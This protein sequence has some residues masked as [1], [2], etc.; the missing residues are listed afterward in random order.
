M[1]EKGRTQAERIPERITF[2]KIH[3]PIEIPHLLDLQKNSFDWLI[4]NERWK[5][6]IKKSQW[7]DAIGKRSGFDEVF[8]EFSPISDEQ[9]RMELTFSEPALEEA[10]YSMQECKE[11]GLT[12]AAPLYVRAEFHDIKKDIRKKQTVF[13][14]DFPLMTET[15][16]FVFN[17]TE[18]VVLTQIA[19]S[20]GVYFEKSTQKGNDRELFS[21]RIVPTRGSWLEFEIDRKDVV[22][23]RVDRKRRQGVI[24]FLKAIGLTN[25]DI[26][27]HFGQYPI[28]MRAFEKNADLTRE[29][30]LESVY[31]NAR[32]GEP[33]NPE[34]GQMLLDNMFFDE[35]RY[36]LSKIGRYKLNKKLGVDEPVENTVLT[37][38]DIISVAQYLCAMHSGKEEYTA[39][40]TKKAKT[41]RIATDDIDHFGNRR[42]R[43]CAELIQNQMRIALTRIERVVR[44]RMDTQDIENIT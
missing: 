7:D 13:F 10:P 38:N 35:K 32:P 22:S 34:A 14:G 16:S 18:R 31:Q 28:I 25:D 30:A 1:T 40:Y 8:S 39:T 44:E 43:R 33:A 2:G 41:V 15:G 29:G 5:Q 11:K 19:R 4:G 23:V 20:P 42:V 6:R 27:K 3:S 26:K 17:G 12:Y 37:N 36:T 9:G 24:H 21:V